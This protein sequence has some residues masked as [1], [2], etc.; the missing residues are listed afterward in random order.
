MVA[1][2]VLPFQYV[3]PEVRGG[4]TSLA[5]LPNYF[6]LAVVAGLRE[7][8]ATHVVARTGEQGWTC[9]Q[10]VLTLVLLNLAGGDSVDDVERLESDD[11]LCRVMRRIEH[12][13]LPRAERR[14]LE[15]RWRKEKQRAFPSPSSVRRWLEA[16]HDESEEALRVPG[17]AFIPAR[18]DALKGLARVNAR[19][20]AFVQAKRPQAMATLDMD[21]TLV[22]THKREALRCYKGYKAYQPLN[23]W[24][25]EQELVIHSEFRDGNVPAGFEQRRV[26]EEALSYLPDSVETVRMRSDTAGYQW[27]LLRYCEEGRHPR[28]GRIEFAVGADIT[29]AFKRAVVTTPNLTW[30]RL[31]PDSPQEWAEVCFVPDEL[32]RTKKGLYR[33]IA[34]REPVRQMELFEGAAQQLPFAALAAQDS[35]GRTTLWKLS[36]V[37]TNR[38]E[39]AAPELIHWYRERCGKSE[40]AHAVMK[41]DLAGGR[42]PAKRFGSDAAWWAVMILA[43]NL[44]AAM[45]HLVLGP[46]WATRRM[47]A[48]RLWFINVPARVA[49]HARALSLHLGLNGESAALLVE[50]SEGIRALG[51]GPAG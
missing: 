21:A 32:S 37:V 49:S 43:M 6:E 47:K 18:R 2:Q 48:V 50:A 23:T 11:G 9:G 44:N 42:L 31:D 5:G 22:E 40:H 45:K 36:A 20:A 35:E 51:T 17:T 25:A 12:H 1:C 4:L 46:R 19:L 7:S 14:A 29:D 15:R 41:D 28:V 33:F 39:V 13:G 3:A 27:D 10:M 16:F 34:V 30:H 26:L 38:T 8:L 24:W